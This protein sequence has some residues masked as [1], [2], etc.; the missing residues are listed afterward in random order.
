MTVRER[1]LWKIGGIGYLTYFSAIPPKG[2]ANW[3]AILAGEERK[4]QFFLA[5]WS[6]FPLLGHGWG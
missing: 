6:Q 2:A 4:R 1:S 5:T 3:K